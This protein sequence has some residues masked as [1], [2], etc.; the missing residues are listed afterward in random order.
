VEPSNDFPRF[1]LATQAGAFVLGVASNTS[2][3]FVPIAMVFTKKRHGAFCLCLITDAVCG[4]SLAKRILER[5]QVRRKE[6]PKHNAQDLCSSR[7]CCGAR[8]CRL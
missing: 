5:P 4:T 8:R 6:A 7:G 1:F 3:P 2:P